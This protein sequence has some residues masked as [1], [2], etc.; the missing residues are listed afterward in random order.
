[1]ESRV[2]LDSARNT[3]I[4]IITGNHETPN[5]T[6]HNME[7]FLQ[8]KNTS[9]E[10][11]LKRKKRHTIS[12]ADKTVDMDDSLSLNDEQ[13]QKAREMILKHD[14]LCN[15]EERQD[16]CKEF[17]T[18]LKALTENNDD[19]K[20]QKDVSRIN[21]KVNDDAVDNKTNHNDVGPTDVSKR[22]ALPLINLDSIIE[23]IPN[24]P[25]ETREAHPHSVSSQHLADTCLLARLL[26]RNYP[27]EKGKRNNYMYNFLL[28]RLI[29]KIF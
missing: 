14:I 2:I 25:L 22:E 9:A 10:L 18:K 12:P 21:L 20:L 15:N 1:M 23:S 19:T 7:I 29:R 26:K 6:V 11:K 17:V 8:Q 28:F 3:E 13:L 4:I 27:S 16:I 24:M 5:V